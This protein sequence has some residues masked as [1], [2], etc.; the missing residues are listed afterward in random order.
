MR[1]RP[2]FRPICDFARMG[3]FQRF[4]VF[5]EYSRAIS[6]GTGRPHAFLFSWLLSRLALRFPFLPLKTIDVPT[7]VN[8]RRLIL[9]IRL[10]T[11][12]TFVAKEIFGDLQYVRD[13][14]P[15]RVTRILDL[16]ANV[17]FASLFLAA[18]YPEALI[19]CVEPDPE[20]LVAL[21]HSLAIN[22]IPATIVEG[23]VAGST[24]QRNFSADSM[25]SSGRMM[26]EGTGIVQVEALSLRDLLLRL[27]WETVDLV[28]IDIEGA[29]HELIVADLEIFRRF[30]H[31]LMELHDWIPKQVVVDS[32]ASVGFTWQLLH[33]EQ[34][35]EVVWFSRE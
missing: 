4:K 30:S 35:G 7:W 28:K 29:E 14:M 24:G 16:G 15:D 32:L 17:G 33:A 12:D 34:G 18:M 2:K 1:I 8:R 22:G 27:N 6:G 19:A 21:R 5:L 20:N 11:T 26:D 31:I 10:N 23:A 9:P 3:Y 13:T 25:P